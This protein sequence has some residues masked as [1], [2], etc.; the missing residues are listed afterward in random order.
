MNSLDVAAYTK[1]WNNKTEQKNQQQEEA[2][3]FHDVILMTIHSPTHSL[4]MFNFAISKIFTDNVFGCCL[5]LD[6]CKS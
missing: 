4:A 6:I 1:R 3:Y 5:K 2:S